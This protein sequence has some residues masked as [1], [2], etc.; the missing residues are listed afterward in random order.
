MGKSECNLTNK[1]F[2]CFYKTI[3]QQEL[4]KKKNAQEQQTYVD[5]ERNDEH[6]DGQFQGR[7]LY[8]V[9]ESQ[10]RQTNT[11]DTHKHRHEPTEQHRQHTFTLIRKFK[12]WLEQSHDT[13]E[14]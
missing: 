11:Y 13:S 5:E 1:T 14:R 10:L 8:G 3:V 9:E 7:I 12:D 6:D 4:K 2:R